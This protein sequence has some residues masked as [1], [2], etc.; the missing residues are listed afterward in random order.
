MLLI[1]DKPQVPSLERLY[2]ASVNEPEQSPRALPSAIV[3]ATA[4]G[5]GATRPDGLLSE[6]V[7]ATMVMT[8]AGA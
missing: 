5:A 8:A 7:L 1:P 2:P 4:M 6:M 3:P